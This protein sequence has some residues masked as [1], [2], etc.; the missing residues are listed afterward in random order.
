MGCRFRPSRISSVGMAE[1]LSQSLDDRSQ[2]AM[3][4]GRE[5]TSQK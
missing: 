4:P 3:K 5:V 1:G 2:T